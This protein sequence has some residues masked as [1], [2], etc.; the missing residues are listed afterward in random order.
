MTWSMKHE[1]F[2]KSHRQ[3]LVYTSWHRMIWAQDVHAITQCHHSANS[4]F[5]S[6]HCYEHNY[7]ES[8][9]PVNHATITIMIVQPLPY[10]PFALVSLVLRQF[11]YKYKFVSCINCANISLSLLAII[12][13]PENAVVYQGIFYIYVPISSVFNK[14]TAKYF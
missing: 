14:Y 8:W 10:C 4:F 12:D 11:S 1:L 7:K 9:P 2:F 13:H 3:N 5:S 6:A